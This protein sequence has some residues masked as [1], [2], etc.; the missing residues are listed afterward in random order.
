MIE[1]KAKIVEALFSGES[2]NGESE[3]VI[4]PYQR[5]YA[6]HENEKD[7]AA[8]LV[9]DLH[10]AIKDKNEGYFLSAIT[11][12][13]KSNSGKDRNNRVRVFRVIDGQQRLIALSL[14][15]RTITEK[16]TDGDDLKERLNSCLEVKPKDKKDKKAEDKECCWPWRVRLTD[17]GDKK[18]F[19][20]I[21]G[22]KKDEQDKEANI[23]K[24][25][26]AVKEKLE[27]LDKG[28]YL[29][30]F[31]KFLLCKTW[32]VEN[33]ISGI[34]EQACQI[35][36][37]L[38]NRGQGLSPYD[39]IKNR[40]FLL[41][42]YENKNEE[43][44]DGHIKKMETGVREHIPGWEERSSENMQDYFRIYLQVNNNKP[45][46]DETKMSQKE[47]EN[48]LVEW[49][50]WDDV[51]NRFKDYTKKKSSEDIMKFA[52][53]IADDKTLMPFY[54]TRGCGLNLEKCEALISPRFNHHLF[55]LRGDWY[56]YRGHWYPYR[57]YY[58]PALFSCFYQYQ[59]GNLSREQVRET[60][61]NLFCHMR[62]MSIQKRHFND[63]VRG[64]LGEFAAEGY[65]S[66][67]P[68][69]ALSRD[70]LKE[71]L[72]HDYNHPWKPLTTE[73]MK[74]KLLDWSSPDPDKTQERITH[75]MA[76]DNI[77]FDI[78]SLADGNGGGMVEVATED[79]DK[80]EVKKGGLI[81]RKPFEWHNHDEDKGGKK[82]DTLKRM[83]LEHILPQTFS[84]SKYKKFTEKEHP[85]W[86]EC[87]GNL[88][89]LTAKHDNEAWAKGIKEKFEK[90]YEKYPHHRVVRNIA[91]Y[92]EKN[93]SSDEE[94]WSPESIKKRGDDL[95]DA[96]VKAVK[97]TWE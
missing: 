45:L 5:R 78:C 3:F 95:V 70:S 2:E 13:R 48:F 79:D 72:S 64:R 1:A 42:G 50:E 6:W 31:A 20:S 86:V 29:A 7:E 68:K 27:G 43:E 71:T 21:I 35:F 33:V 89:I 39:L 57:D 88:T 60:L 54:V 62:R 8:Q 41:A 83:S 38:N 14:I 25:Y 23:V 65:N 44:M 66:E 46:P 53:E 15:M 24:S 12:H 49:V 40:L 63:G 81:Y 67:K 76:R 52:E 32:I 96:Y 90:F 19:N 92:W 28:D 84:K 30:E 34:G 85:K 55:A 36:G 69:E 80:E 26:Q 47:V 61:A 51:Y 97:F 18:A 11:L 16:L 94:W 74:Q 56:P 75:N 77:L 22:G 17:E 93:S 58:R 73:A 9:E 37:H 87:L 10:E 4:P 59:K 82:H 91:N